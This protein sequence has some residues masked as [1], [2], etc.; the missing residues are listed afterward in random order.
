LG[1][2]L[3]LSE[4]RKNLE[5]VIGRSK[6]TKVSPRFAFGLPQGSLISSDSLVFRVLD[7][8]RVAMQLAPSNYSEP[9]FKPSNTN[10]NMLIEDIEITNEK[11][12][13]YHPQPSTPPP[14]L[15]LGSI[16]RGAHTH[17]AR[18]CWIFL[19]IQNHY[20]NDDRNCNQWEWFWGGQHEIFVLG[21]FRLAA[22]CLAG[23]STNNGFSHSF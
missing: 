17:R 5:R 15:P 12:P 11:K 16:P 22:H 21:I 6:S 1:W 4:R 7:E 20:I 8:D 13:P 19:R 2:I 10:T 23:N 18:R 14:P 9:W 3:F